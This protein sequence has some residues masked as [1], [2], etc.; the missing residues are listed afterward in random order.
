MTDRFR[1]RDD[2]GASVVEMAFVAIFLFIL[3]AGMIDLGRAY[4]TRIAI[5]DAAQEGAMFASY[6]PS[7]EEA[8]KERVVSTTSNPDLSDAEI[9]VTCPEGDPVLGVGGKK[10]AVRVTYDLPLI[11]PIVGGMLGGHIELSREHVGTVFSG[12]CLK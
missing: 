3:V 7:D 5:Y 8:I 1:L 12:E 9:E 11:T 4:L 6:R 2:R 10:V